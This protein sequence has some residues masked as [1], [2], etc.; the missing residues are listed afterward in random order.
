MEPS[1]GKESSFGLSY[2][3]LTKTNYTA[4][5]LKMK[6]F[7]QAHGVLE[8]I[9]PKDAAGV[10]ED[11]TDKRALA[12][13]YQGIPEDLLLSLADKQMSKETWNA[14]KMMCLGAE[15]VKMARA[16]TLKGEFEGLVIKETDQIDEFYLKL[17]GLVTNIRALGE[18]MEEAYVVKK[19]LKAVPFKFLQITSAIEQFGNLEQM[20]VEEV[21][22]SLKAHEERVRGTVEQTQGQLLLTEDEWRKQESNNDGQLLLSREEWIKR[23]TGSDSRRREESRGGRDRSRV[24]CFKCQ[25]YGHYA[26]ECRKPR[27]ERN[28]SKEVNLS[29]IQGDEPALL[30][31]EVGKI[32]H[33]TGSELLLLNEKAMVP[34]LQADIG[35]QRESQVWYLDNGASNH[36]TGQ[37]GKFKELDESMTGHVKFGDGSIVKIKGKGCVSFKCKNGEER[38]L[39]EVYFIPTLCNNIIS[40]GQLSEA[41]NKVV[42]D[43]DYLWVY[44]E[45]GRL[46]MK[47]KRSK[48]RLYKISLEDSNSN[49][50]LAK[51]EED[52]WLWYARLGH[53]NF[54]AMEVMSREEMVYGIPKFMQPLKR[55]EGCLLSKQARKPFPHQANSIA[56]Q[57]LEIVHADICG[58]IQPATRGGNR[59]F[60]LFVDNFSHKMWVYMLKEKSAA[61]E[62]FKKFKVLVETRTEKR[63]KIL[64]TDRGGEFC[65]REFTSYCENAGILRH[66][67]TPYTPQ[68]NGVVECRNCTVV[69][70]TRSFL[71]E[72][73]L[74]SFLWGEAVRHSVYIL[75]RL[76]T[77]SL[78][79]RTPYEAWCGKRPDLSHVKVFGRVAFMKIPT[80]K[81]TKLDDRSKAVIYLGK[82]P[83]TKGNRLF[84]PNTG[85]VHVSRDV[86][87]QENELWQWE[88]NRESEVTF[89]VS[90]VV[91]NDNEH[92]G[93]VHEH[94]QT[95]PP[96]TSQSAES[97]YSTT[98]TTPNSS[99][100]RNTTSSEN[101]E[102]P[103]RY[104]NLMELYEETE[105][106]E[107]PEFELMLL[108]IEGPE[109][110]K[111]AV[112][113]DEWKKAMT[114]EIETIE[115]NKT[116]VLTE[117]P[118]GHKPIGIKWVYKL[119]KDSEGNVVKHKA[120][121]VAKGYVQTKGI[122]Y[123]EVFAPVARMETIR[124]ILALSA[125]KGWQVHH[126][127]VKSAFLN[128]ILLEEVYVS[129]PEGFEKKG[130]EHKVYRLFKALYGLRQAPRAWNTRL[131]ECLK[132]LGFKKCLH[133]QAVYTRCSN[134][135]TLIIGVYVDDLLVA[136]SNKSEIEKFK[137]QM[138]EKFEMSDLGLLS[139]YLGIEVNQGLGFTTVKQT[140]YAKKILEKAGMMYCNATKVPMEC[141]LQLDKDKEGQEVNAN[142]YRSIVG[143][144][145]YLT[146]TR[147]DISYAVGVISR[148]MERPTV[149]HQQAIK[150]VLR[151]IKG[152]VNYGL[153]YASAGDESTQDLCGYSDSD[154][155]EDVTDR[156]S[157]RGM[158]FYLNGGLI[159]WASQ[160]QRVIALSSC[161]AEYMAATYAACQSI[162][163]RGLLQEITGQ[164]TRPVIL[165]VDN[166]SAIELMK[167]PVL[168]GRSKHIDVRFHFIREC[169]ERGELEVEF[170]S[171]DK[172]RA[173]ILTKALGKIKF[174][175]LRKLVGVVDLASE[176]T[177]NKL[178][179]SPSYKWRSIVAAQDLWKQGCRKRIG[180]RMETFVWQI[181]WLP[182]AVDGFILT[183]IPTDFPNIKQWSWC[184][185]EK[186]DV[187]H[188]LFNCSFAR[189]VW[190]AASLENWVQTGHGESIM[191]HFNRL[192]ASGM[193]EQYASLALFCRSIWN[194][195]NRSPTATHGSTRR[196]QAPMQTLVKINVDASI[197]GDAETIGV[198]G[199]VRDEKGKFL[200]AMCNQLSGSRTP[201]EAE[202]LSLKEVLT[203]EKNSGYVR[204]IID[205][206]SK[207]LV[208]AYNG[209]TGRF[210]F[211]SIVNDYVELVKHFENVLVPFVHRS[212]NEVAHLLARVSHS[213]SGL[214]EWEE[215]VPNY[216]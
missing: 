201:R 44:E 167:N 208:D 210:Y 91:V 18:K 27:R 125:K 68:Q 56:K 60:I 162:W 102:Q 170:V 181:P 32:E 200:R 192:F 173:D 11:K 25:A 4:W 46:L 76:P 69:A 161:E 143:S 55:C 14:V 153:S 118:P 115:K 147:P 71:K 72:S 196:W 41:G 16:Q 2:P 123:E 107:H 79:G 62:M 59:Y 131:D 197:F 5:A 184:R 35:H 193:K 20:S 17:N 209:T 45:G 130:E 110:Y 182:C 122:D 111:E 213:M 43:G 188:A 179:D 129:Q 7:M 97:I 160:K 63:I 133:E 112:M 39:K 176:N 8:A 117:L 57:A 148:F 134:G 33:M 83:G 93:M 194:R 126:L 73:K 99:S 101:S 19:L 185:V 37:R 84:D 95:T 183:N 198:G 151:Y 187:K 22:G 172:Q 140:S 121:L 48:N 144:L 114:A 216:L 204:C 75:N 36:M 6:V 165:H 191:E 141:K 199:V 178:G 90:V 26:A 96:H 145:R 86:V 100:I 13:I 28:T 104:R 146:H 81:V 38:V 51:V 180:T 50:L 150:H 74:P 203:W 142:N 108:K 120:R 24:R 190:T 54:Q 66:Y 211:H 205:T 82:E 214:R 29:V 103:M 116:W 139:Y 49:C 34:K 149:K 88:E 171:T 53:V 175:G 195:R 61:F 154:L 67:T 87:V 23:R 164:S 119:K 12:I 186:E 80:V 94:E 52:T 9:E 85:A 127:D 135:E 109:S 163:L 31:A 92:T 166:K 70:M 156:R 58:P 113:E 78:N 157:T 207:L 212:A 137:L 174:E 3:M 65:S 30:I 21:I 155:A 206:D 202:A 132:E 168:H 124:L 215:V 105:R 138:N 89:P 77:R 169:I 64:R 189:S 1:K 106:I 152:T 98:T 40:L 128:G 15:K 42:I 47:V 159:S 10:V 177:S 158:C 136:G